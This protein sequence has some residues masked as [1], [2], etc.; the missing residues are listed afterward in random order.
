MSL[1]RG[2]RRRAGGRDADW[3]SWGGKLA[4]GCDRRGVLGAVTPA[5]GE[6]M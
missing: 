5:Q 2:R 4:R 3:L 6:D 1:T